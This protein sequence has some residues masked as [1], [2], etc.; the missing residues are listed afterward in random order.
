MEHLAALSP[1]VL[2]VATLV[3]LI[4]GIVKGVVGFAMPMILISGLS[5][6]MAPEVALAALIVPTLMSNLWL[7]LRQGVAAAWHSMADH[8]RFLTVILIA[9]AISAQFVTLL[10]Q[11]QLFLIIGIP[12]VTFAIIQLVGWEPM[13]EARHRRSFEVG[14]GLFAGAVGGLAGNWGSPTVLYLLALNT[15]KSDAMRIQGVVFGAG[16]I[17]LLLA[18]LKSGVLS[19]ET[20][21]LSLAML[22]PTGVGMLMGFAIGDRIDQK[23]FR[24]ITLLV[25]I[26]AGLNLIRRGLM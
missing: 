24:R 8:L 25:L 26:V 7:A 18:H 6:V 4:A 2:I 16:S 9:I 1:G 22:V 12:I 15:P 14:A 11:Q 13:I 5:S 10:S 23:R 19:A 17:V 21:P 3:G 20:A